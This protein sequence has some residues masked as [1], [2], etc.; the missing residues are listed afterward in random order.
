M[1]PPLTL[2]CCMAGLIGLAVASPAAFAHAPT[3]G[4]SPKDARPTVTRFECID[5]DA[6]Q[7][8]Q[9]EVLRVRGE[10][11]Q[12][13]RVVMFLGR[14]GRSDDRTAPTE[15]RSP[16][17]LIVRVPA[18]ATTGPVRVRSAAAGLSPPSR[19]L[20]VT[21]AAKPALAAVAVAP[22]EGTFPVRGK[23]GFG[24]E[25]NRFGGGRG[26]EGQDI[27]ASCGAP[28]VSARS[29]TVTFAK[30]QDR[31]GNYAVIT[32]DDGTSQAYM[33]M[34]APAAVQ[35]GQRV[36]AGQP[37]GQVGQTGRADGCH[38]HFELWTAPGWYQGGQ[39]VDPLPELQRYA[40]RG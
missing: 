25:I 21:A 12:R 29:G 27:F 8:P 1:P 14:R 18:D 40:A 11:L 19:R 31:A 7:C 26:H 17:R 3:G 13:A 28:L 24:T 30:F 37:I 33:H 35:R 34:L 36:T 6:R 16:H 5:G 15:K 20:K 9:G 22:D 10:G 39:A 38:L 2:R 23:Y 4:A 32:A